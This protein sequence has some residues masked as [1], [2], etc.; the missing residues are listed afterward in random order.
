MAC[1]RA[2]PRHRRPR[3]PRRLGRAGCARRRRRTSSATTSGDDRRAWSSSSGTTAERVDARARR[4]HRPRAP[5]TR[6]RRPR[7]RASCTSPRSRCRSSGRTRR[8]GCTSTSRARS[9]SSRRWRGGSTGSPA[10]RTRARR[11]STPVATPPPRPRPADRA[12]HPVRRLEARRRGDGADLRH[13]RGLAVDRN[14]ALRRLR[15]RARPGDDVRADRGDAAAARGEPYAIGFTGRAQYDYAPDV[16][17]RVRDG[18]ARRL[19]GAAVYNVPGA[20]ATVDDVDRRDPRRPARRR[21]HRARRRAPVSGGARGGRL[22]PG[23]RAVPADAPRRRGRRD[24]RALPG[25]L[26]GHPAAIAR[27]RLAWTP[28]SATR[29]VDIAALPGAREAD[30]RAARL[31]WRLPAELAPLARIAL[32][33]RWAWDPDGPELFRSLDPH[34]WEINGGNPVRQLEDLPPHAAEPRRAT[35]RSASASSGWR[36]CSRRIARVPRRPVDGIGGPVAFFCAEYGDPPSLPDLLGRPRRARRRHPQGG[37]RPRACRWSASACC[38]ARAT[39]SQRI[40]RSGLAARVLGRD[41]SPSACRPSLVTGADGAPLTVTS[42]SATARSRPVWRVEVGRVPL[43]PARHRARP[44]TTPVDRWITARLYERRPATR[45]S[46]STCC[47]ASAACARCARSASS[48]ASC[49]STRATPRSPRSSSRARATLR[50]ERLDDALVA[51]RERTRLHDPHAGAGGQRHVPGRTRSPR[52]SRDLAGD[53]SAIDAERFVAPR[54]HAPDDGDEPVGDD[55]SSRSALSRA[56]QRRQPRATARSRARCGTRLWPDRAVDDVPI[57]HVTNGVHIPTG[58]ARPMREL[59]DRHLGDGLARPRHRSRDLGAGRRHPGRGAVGGAQR[60]SARSWST[61]SARAASHDRLARG[62]DPRVRRGG[63]RDVRPEDALTIGFAR[64]IA[65]YKR[66]DLLLARRRARAARSRR[67][68]AASRCSSPARRTRATTT[69]SGSSASVRAFE[70]APASPA[71]SPTSTTTTSP[72][73]RRSSRGC[74]VWV[75]VPRPPL[76]ASGTSGMKSAVN[77]GLSLSVL[78]GWW[79]EG[80]DGENGWAIDGGPEGEDEAR[81][82]PATPTRSTTCSSRR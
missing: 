57:T 50:G 19:R 28:V 46:A 71:A 56:R 7:S 53:G 72:S 51:A 33:Y 68:T 34:A 17:A 22:R 67:R 38:T 25:R 36:R 52:R 18:R 37:E 11:P 66:L 16:G 77:G 55:A 15:P 41:R 10:S 21:D 12:R 49:T 44:R 27:R 42:R 3:L 76:E 45:G 32:D 64:R 6:P 20:P 47:S 4:H 75:N 29:I 40:D 58:S 5:R 14:P 61:T 60:R 78:D 59:L 35:R 62:E 31:A 69:A 9:T 70:R 74:D 81:R 65:T 30:E 23:R 13:G 73:P 26:T 43:L 63:R 80:Y 8:S 79:A 54:P 82:M 48:P 24:D 1:E 39:S 2:L